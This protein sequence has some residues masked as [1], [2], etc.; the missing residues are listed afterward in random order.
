M[1]LYK[2]YLE[3]P[4]EQWFSTWGRDPQRSHEPF[5]SGRE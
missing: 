3:R 4:Q 1:G 5:W 2:D